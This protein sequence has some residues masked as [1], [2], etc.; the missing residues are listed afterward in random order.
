[1]YGKYAET[2]FSGREGLEI[3]LQ[4]S[5]LRISLFVTK[6]DYATVCVA[7][8]SQHARRIRSSPRFVGIFPGMY[9][10]SSVRRDKYISMQNG[11]ERNGAV[12]RDRTFRPS[13][14]IT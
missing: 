3:H 12:R 4:H 5:S 8:L 13:S 14:R 6:L 10:R 9:H 7:K 11:T 2:L 1:V